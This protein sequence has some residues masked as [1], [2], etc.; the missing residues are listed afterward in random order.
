MGGGGRGA[1]V[2]G[3]VEIGHLLSLESVPFWLHWGQKFF[4]SIPPGVSNNQTVASTL[5]CAPE[6]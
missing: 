2:G 5:Q 4:L 1:G 6:L 3:R